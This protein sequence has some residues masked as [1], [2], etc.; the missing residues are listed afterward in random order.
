MDLTTAL[1]RAQKYDRSWEDVLLEFKNHEIE[2]YVFSLCYYAYK[3][4]VLREYFPA[5]REHNQKSIAFMEELCSLMEF[6]AEANDGALWG[7]KFVIKDVQMLSVLRNEAESVLRK[8]LDEFDDKEFHYMTFPLT[9]DRITEEW[10]KRCFKKIPVN[11]NIAQDEDGHFINISLRFHIS[12]LNKAIEETKAIPLT[13]E[14]YTVIEFL[15]YAKRLGVPLNNATY[16]DLYQM[17]REYDFIPKEILQSH[18]SNTQRYVR[19]NYI[20]AIYRNNPWMDN[21]EPIKNYI[22]KDFD[23][24]KLMKQ[25]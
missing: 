1:Q 23:K 16:R 7:E 18:D 22:P 25:E 19:E 5:V 20:K 24:Y 3:I 14:E 11:D 21:D 4:V 9:P 15:S 13:Y 12:E 17:M 6:I 10:N 2:Q 8:R